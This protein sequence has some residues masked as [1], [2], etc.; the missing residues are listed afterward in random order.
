[1]RLIEFYKV[2][3][4]NY[5]VEDF[6]DYI[7]NK[8]GVVFDLRHIR[9]NIV[10]LESLQ[11]SRGSPPGTGSA[12]MQELIDW[13]DKNGIFLTLQ[14][15]KKGYQPARGGKTTTSP[16]RLEKFYRRFGFR[17][18]RGRY[19]RFELSLYTSMYR[20]P[21][22]VNEERLDEYFNATGWTNVKTNQTFHKEGETLAVPP[23]V[24][25]L[26]KYGKE[27]GIDPDVAASAMDSYAGPA[28]IQ[29]YQNGWVRWFYTKQGDI[30]YM[31]APELLWK[32]AAPL[33][34]KLLKRYQ[35]QEVRLDVI[36]PT[37]ATGL[38]NQLSG[39]FHGTD[40][41]SMNKWFQNPFQEYLEE[42][43]DTEKQGDKHES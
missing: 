28:Q 15:S 19:K 36:D 29:A 18:N 12:V 7:V 3:E 42:S 33:A 23:H 21:R 20:E 24:T 11:A 5:G 32:S 43:I 25:Y 37:S 38:D 22:Q 34:M 30:L 13:A 14:L 17:P 1:M 40:R 35:P 8:H 39:T 10:D 31:S 6:Q 16:G 27:M 4:E 2:L 41:M 26:R 9:D